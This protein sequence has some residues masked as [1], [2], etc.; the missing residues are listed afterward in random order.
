[1]SFLWQLGVKTGNVCCDTKL[2]EVLLFLFLSISSCPAETAAFRLW[3]RQKE[4]LSKEEARLLEARALLEK[5]KL[6]NI[7]WM[8]H[9]RSLEMKEI[10]TLTTQIQR[11]LVSRWVDEIWFSCEKSV[12]CESP[13]SNRANPDSNSGSILKP[14]ILLLQE[15]IKMKVG[16]ETWKQRCY[17]LSPV[18]CQNFLVWTF[19]VLK[20]Q[21]WEQATVLLCSKHDCGFLLK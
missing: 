8:W 16:I 19:D 20:D 5:K 10:L 4:L 3:R 2:F 9:S 6:R 1:M 17:D 13:R 12:C 18:H 15:L 14:S 21:T 7:F 11:N